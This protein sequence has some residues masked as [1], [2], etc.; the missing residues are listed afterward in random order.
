VTGKNDML[1]RPGCA[2]YFEGS[3]Y[4]VC[5]RAFTSSPWRRLIGD[6]CSKIAVSPEPSSFKL[7][8]V[9]RAR[10]YCCFRE[11]FRRSSTRSCLSLVVAELSWAP[12]E[13][14]CSRESAMR[15][16]P[17]ELC[18]GASA[19]APSRY[20]QLERDVDGALAR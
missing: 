9:S 12:V 2:I 18:I 10:R 14:S 7:W 19:A 11:Q 17:K 20:T 16:W 13:L 4:A 15:P 1:C 8:S 6:W 3:S 5:L